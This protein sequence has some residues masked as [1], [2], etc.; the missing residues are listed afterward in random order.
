MHEKRVHRNTV[1]FSPA[2]GF[3]TRHPCRGGKASAS[4]LAS[5]RS[6]IGAGCDARRTQGEGESKALLFLAF[7]IAPSRL[8][9]SI[10]A[11]TGSDRHG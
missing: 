9:P 10:A 3:P 5:L 1:R 8:A 11:Q 7:D 2:P 6:L 4:C